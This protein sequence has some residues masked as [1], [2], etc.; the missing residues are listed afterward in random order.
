MKQKKSN[1]SNVHYF[2]QKRKHKP[3]K[4]T[5]NQKVKGS[6]LVSAMTYCQC[7]KNQITKKNKIDDFYLCDKCHNLTPPE[8]YVQITEGLDTK[9]PQYVN[10]E[11]DLDYLYHHFWLDGDK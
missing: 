2:D 8:I 4:K 5:N 6:K 1:C 7:C 11:D 10:W 3:T 9:V